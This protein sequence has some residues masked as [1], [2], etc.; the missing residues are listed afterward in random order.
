MG[1]TSGNLMANSSASCLDEHAKWTML[2]AAQRALQSTTFNPSFRM[3]PAL[4]MAEAFI[5]SEL[6]T[7]KVF[8][9][10]KAGSIA[11]ILE[12]LYQRYMPSE[13]TARTHA[14]TTL[15]MPLKNAKERLVLAVQTLHARPDTLRLLHTIGIPVP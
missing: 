14:L 12:L 7:Q 13:P 10:R 15:V 5:K 11:D 8:L 1:S 2:T 4:S 3:I 9:T 6:L